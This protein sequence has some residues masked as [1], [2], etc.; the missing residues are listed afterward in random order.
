MKKSEWDSSRLELALPLS[1]WSRPYREWI[2]NKL[3][4]NTIF[5]HII[6]FIKK[7]LFSCRSFPFYYFSVHAKRSSLLFQAR[8]STSTR[9]A[10]WAGK[11]FS[12]TSTT[13]WELIAAPLLAIL[14]SLSAFLGLLEL[15]ENMRRKARQ[16]AALNE[17]INID[18]TAEWD[19]IENNSRF[20]PI[21]N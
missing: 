19:F 14:F 8:Q 15:R 7:S 4:F 20:E 18:E 10:F 9:C 5:L 11:S 3:I 6:I 13:D 2:N 16:K 12:S 21:A 1:W 17:I